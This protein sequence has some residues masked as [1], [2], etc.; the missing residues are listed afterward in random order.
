M[1]PAIKISMLFSILVLFCLSAAG[2]GQ[3]GHKQKME[4]YR[5]MKIAYFTE[6]LELMPDE[7]EKFW[8]LYN[9]HEQKREELRRE[10]R[11]S[12][13]QY[14]E[15]AGELSEEETEAIVD[16][17]VEIRKEELE[18]D[19]KF[20]EDLKNILPASKVMKL[21]MTEVQFREYM[22]RRIREDRGGHGRGREGRTPDSP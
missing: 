1:K 11:K 17:I 9:A 18:L 15:Q 7:A 2:Q 10:T 12:T 4:R 14:T 19:V 8:P 20:H 21:Y 6:N 22:L 13:R 5:S 16:R 3:E